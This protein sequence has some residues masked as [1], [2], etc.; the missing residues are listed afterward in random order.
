MQNQ[1]MRQQ[2]ADR[3]KDFNEFAEQ[4][5]NRIDGFN[6]IE[7]ENEVSVFM[8]N[9]VGSKVILFLKFTKVQSSFG[10]LHLKRAEKNGIPIGKSIFELQKNSLLHKWSQV[11][12]IIETL[13]CHE[14]SR[15]DRIK[16]LIKN[17]Q[18]L[19]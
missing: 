8:T 16:K 1:G 2:D 18:E 9:L 5:D 10:F 11:K 14:P 7:K 6:V 15:T 4:V 17:C 12:N 13:K 3:I 19:S